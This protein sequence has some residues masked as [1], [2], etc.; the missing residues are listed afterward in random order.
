MVALIWHPDKVDASKRE[1]AEDVFKKVKEA[2][3]VL[4]DG[5]YLRVRAADI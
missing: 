5:M 3:E 1:E 2:Y 4:S